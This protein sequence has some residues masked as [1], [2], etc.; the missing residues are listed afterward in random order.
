M[1][2]TPEERA[3]IRQAFGQMPL[4]QKLDYIWT[5]YKIPIVAAAAALF[6]L[7]SY[8][9]HLLTQKK[10]LLYT[11][12]VNVAAGGD[13]L[14][15]LDTGF[16]TAQGEAPARTQVYLYQDLYLTQEASDENHEYAYASRLKVMAAI[17][18]QQ[19]D[20]VLMNREAYDLLSQS[21]YL[22]PLPELL[23][24]D[25]ALAAALD[26]WLAENTVVLSD[27]A[28]EVELGEAAAYEAE[29]EQ[30]VN[31]VRAA[32]LPRL[33]RAGFDG[34]VFVGVIGNTPRAETVLAYLAF[35]A[36]P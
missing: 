7:V 35:L 16:V 10:P 28:I 17:T 5:Y 33:V 9:G 8:G 21:G 13:L 36:A 26:P 22:L 11:A 20:V 29:T 18:G 32:G 30:A 19:L 15:V 4:R 31:A 25:A 34:E 27:N 1:K 12:C 14:T 2:L 3:N 24:G 6:F 23:A